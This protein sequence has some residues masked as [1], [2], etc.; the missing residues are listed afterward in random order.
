MNDLGG[1]IL[2]KGLMTQFPCARGRAFVCK[3]IGDYV[4]TVASR[5]FCP[6]FDQYVEQEEANL[7]FPKDKEKIRLIMNGW[8][9]WRAENWPPSE[10]V[11]PLLIS[12]HFSPLREKQLLTEEGIAFLKK[13]SPVGCRDLYTEH[14]LK[15]KGIP[16]YFSACVTLTLGKNYKYLGEREGV[17]FVDPYFDIPLLREN[18]KLK[19][20]EIFKFVFY[21]ISHFQCVNTLAKK[22]FFKEYSNTGFLDRNIKAYRPYY[23]AYLF[24][25]TYKKKFEKKM[26]LN[27]EYITHWIDVD[28]AKATN[29][30]LISYAESLVK[31]Y[32]R[33]KM[34]IT[35]RIHAGLPCLGVETPVVFVANDEVTSSTGNFNTP[36]RLD[37][38]LDF[39]R[40]LEL[41]NNNFS[42]NDE[43]F[44]EINLFSE[45]TVFNNKDNWK[46]YA[47]DLKAK[48][49]KFMSD[50]V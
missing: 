3:N 25:K 32:A 34:V 19:V 47:N 26:L 1:M 31:K 10:Y 11:Y 23:K 27:A 39:F 33:A 24:Y 7:F 14:L 18:N 50:K 29:D 43:V 28:M 12:M 2:K 5:Q 8:F 9:Q 17:F 37:G 30:Q 44:N 13:Y 35:S 38:L 48:C 6:D 49:E 41:S 36:G 21:Y 4:Q 40:I 45:N 20:G 42:S 16:A 15:E 22:Q 46:P